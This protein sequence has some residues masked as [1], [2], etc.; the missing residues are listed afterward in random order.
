MIIVRERVEKKCREEKK[1]RDREGVSER[2]TDRQTERVS[3]SVREREREIEIEREREREREMNI[4]SVTWLTMKTLSGQGTVIIQAEWTRG[5]QA[6]CQV[7]S[8]FTRYIKLPDSS[9]GLAA[10]WL[11]EV[12]CSNLGLV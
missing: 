4:L 11:R 10:D 6:E 5:Q 3:E 7:E 1:E 12:V 2:Q 9:L 8:C